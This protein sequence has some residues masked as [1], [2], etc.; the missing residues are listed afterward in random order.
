MVRV[1]KLTEIQRERMLKH[2]SLCPMFETQP[3]IIGP[4][5]S[6]RRVAIITT[7]GLHL[8]N[9][10]PFQFGQH[11][12]YRVIPGNVKANSLLMSHGETSFDRT[13][14]QQDGN[15]VFPI[16]RLHEMASEGIIGSVA[17][18]HYSFGARMSEEEHE[19]SAREIA[20]LLKKDK[21]TAALFFPV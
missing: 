11:D 2:I 4:P 18:F 19:I 6:H 14:F 8:P 1:E 15:M 17:A 7:A 10:R 13:G 3:W 12:L 21:V 5:L 20:G 9:D 16:D